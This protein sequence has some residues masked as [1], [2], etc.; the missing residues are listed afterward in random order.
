MQKAQV[1]FKRYLYYKEEYWKQKVNFNWFENSDRN[2]R[3]FHYLVKERRKRLMLT[4]I[5]NQQ[6]ML[7]EEKEQIC[8]E[9]VQFYQD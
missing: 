9:A 6:G 1:E 3:F 2:I 8:V 7:L 4:K 5:L